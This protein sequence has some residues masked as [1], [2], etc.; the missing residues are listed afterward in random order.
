MTAILLYF[1]SGFVHA[2]GPWPSDNSWNVITS[3]GAPLADR[4]QD[5]VCQDPTNGGA[6]PSQENDIGSQSKCNAAPRYNPGFRDEQFTPGT[7]QPGATIRNTYSAA[8]YY[9]DPNDDSNGCNGIADDTFYFRV[10]IAGDPLDNNA[11]RGFKN[12]FWWANLDIDG[13]NLTDFY[14]RVDGNG[15]KPAENITLI[16]EEST[17]PLDPLD[18][19][20]TGEPTIKV[21]A[22]PLD[23]AI[24]RAILTDNAV[25][26]GGEY[27]VDWQVPITDFDNSGGSQLLCH[28]N[29]MV[30]TNYSTSD[31]NQPLSPY[32]KDYIQ[33]AGTVSDRID[34]VKSEYKITKT[35]TDVNGVPLY[36]GDEVEYTI[37]A[38]NLASN[39]TNFVFTDAIPAGASYVPN[40]IKVILA[41]TTYNMTDA[42][43]TP[44]AGGCSPS[45]NC[46]ADYNVTT[47]G[48]ITVRNDWIYAAGSANPL[49]D[50]IYI[51]FRVTYPL[52]G[53]YYNQGSGVTVELPNKQLTDDP[54]IDDL[55]DCAAPL[56]Y[57]CG[58]GDTGNDDPTGVT[59]AAPAPFANLSVTKTD[60]ITS[61][62][63]GNTL[64]YTITASNAGPFAVVGGTVTDNFPAALTG[65]T[66][67]CVASGGSSCTGAGIG[68][69]NDSAVNLLVGGTATYTVNATV[70]P[71]ASGLL[72]NT[73]TI[74]T[75]PAN[76]DP[77]LSNNTASDSDTLVPTDFGDAPDPAYPTLLANNGARHSIAT[78]FYL[79]ATVDQ[80]PNGQ[81]NATATG[82]D[83][84]G[85]DDEDGVNF[86]SP[87][88]QGYSA[89]LTVSASMAGKLDAWVDFNADGDWADGSEQVFAS[90]NLSA[91]ANAISFAVPA[92]ATLGTTTARFRFS[93]AGGLSYTGSAADGEV[94]DHQL[95]ILAQPNLNTSTKADNDVDNT[96]DP[97]QL[98]TYTVTVINTGGSTATGVNISDT[99]DTDLENLSVI[100]VNNC[101]GAVNSSTANPPV[102]NITGAS[103]AVGTN[104]IITF[105]ANVKPGALGGA[106]IPNTATISAPAEGGPGAAPI[107]DLLTVASI[108][109]LSTSTK[110]DDDG[111][112]SVTNGQTV[113]Y[114]VTVI[115]TGNATGTGINITDTLDTD[116]DNLVVTGITSCGAPADLSVNSPAALNITGASVAVGTNCV[117]TFTADVKL[118][119]PGGSLI[120]NAATISPA[121]E[122]GLGATASSD[123]LAIGA[124]IDLSSSY[125]T[126]NDADDI[127]APGDT[128]T[129]TINVNNTGNSNATGLTV[130]DLIDGDVGAP[131]NF[132]YSGCGAPASGFIA[133]T[134]TFTGVDVAALAS[135]SISY[136]VT[137]DNPIID[138]APETKTVTNSA[139][140][141]PANGS[142]TMTASALSVNVT[143]D[144]STSTKADDD[145]D[146][147]V[148]AG[149]T[150]TYTVTINN[151]GDG[152]ASG[153]SVTDNA[154]FNFGNLSV[155][156][157][158]ACGGSYVNSSTAE[159]PVLNI[160]GIRS[161]PGTPCV[162]T[163]TM[164]VDAGVL[165]GTI[166]ANTANI[167]AALE[168]GSGAAPL[169][170]NLSI[171]VIPN[172]STSTKVDNDADNLVNN[173][174]IVDYTIT[175]IN[176][177]NGTG[178]GISV[179]DALDSD[180]ES[181]IVASFTGCGTPTNGSSASPPILS[182]SGISVALGTNCTI[183]YS[184][185]VKSDSLAGAT[186]PNSA[187]ISAAAEG[188]AGAIPSSDTLTIP[189]NP[190]LSTS[191]KAD[192]DPD[193][194][195][196]NG[197]TVTYTL[198]VINTGNGTGTGVNITD[199]LDTDMENLAVLSINNCGPAVDA[200]VANPPAIN[201][202]G[203]SVGIVAPCTITYTA[204]VKA[205]APGGATIPNTVTVSA[206]SEGG[207]GASPSSDLLAVGAVIDLSGSTKT[208]GDADN[209][210]NPG[211]FVTYS[212]NVVNSG[213][214]NGTGFTVT[215]MIDT[216]YGVP[217]AFSYTG[218][219]A[220]VSSFAAPTLT[221]T[222]VSVAAA[223]TCTIRYTVN[224]DNPLI[225]D[226]PE[227][228]PVDNSADIIPPN[229]SSTS[230][231]NTLS[232]N[233][234]PDLSTSTL[235]DD[236]ADDQVTP[237]QTVTYTLTINNTGDGTATG[238]DINDIIDTNFGNLIVTNISNCGLSY[239]DTSSNE[240]PILTI[241]NLKA[242]PG[243]ACVVTFTAVTDAGLSNGTLLN[244][245][246]SLSSPNE[247]G[248]STGLS[249][250]QLTV[251]VAAPP[252]PPPPPP[253][254]PGSSPGGSAPSSDAFLKVIEANKQKLHEAPEE[255]PPY[256]QCM[257]YNPNRDLYF[258]DVASAN[259]VY[260]K[261]AEILKNTFIVKNGYYIVSGYGSFVKDT[262]V[263][264]IGL[265]RAM[266]RLEWAKILMT[267]HCLPI[268]YTPE[269]GTETATGQPMPEFRDLSRAYNGDETHDRHADMMYSAAYYGILDGTLEGNAEENRLITVAES[270]K[271]LVRTGEIVRKAVSPTADTLV[272]ANIDRNAWYFEFY[273]KAA[274][275]GIIKGLTSSSLKTAT[276][277]V[278]GEAMYELLH[279]LLVRNLYDI[280]Y[281]LL[282]RD[283]LN[284]D[285]LATGKK[286][287]G[288]PA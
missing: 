67:T 229:G 261:T 22:N 179:T 192:D 98:V 243:T 128:V 92:G 172:L 276:N 218:C 202:T 273:S 5:G 114:T 174:Q 23:S 263:R 49:Y 165:G 254:P 66:W 86:T 12:S 287:K 119:S 260:R 278:R 211:D 124:N 37:T 262:G 182:I 73:V 7:L 266:T 288:K 95:T 283:Y 247:G 252:P 105:T 196:A 161:D 123:T 282:I 274:A 166:L 24:A 48:A 52:I 132:A 76:S 78:G 187:T 272:N 43:D 96:V 125:K 277:L 200:S 162:I 163:F 250:S 11:A 138:A 14:V 99:M 32:Q 83:L 62:I 249:A 279:A 267:S 238:I 248:G 116:M 122:G 228:E 17:G 199:T 150:V 286:A 31:A 264:L 58:D 167:S 106:T 217:G 63:P 144:L 198:S 194:N 50:K 208:D 214:A 226:D 133:P 240:P 75:P 54:A 45:T 84:A 42:A 120:P 241:A 245:N 258:S 121:A 35:A 85:S 40:S 93:T 107:S 151:T 41:G 177:G 46:R 57:N 184:A 47:P 80:E 143:P 100:S 71:N 216:N 231:A 271:M 222:N 88:I 109:N 209:L 20:P 126:E 246:L 280:K 224:V 137:V 30:L 3:N 129:Y 15:N 90:Q 185:S 79:G 155:V 152:S 101:G 244:H 60:G 220:P 4:E 275:E 281:Q 242:N 65:V 134:L 180:L 253:A 210:V 111:D 234:T 219:G 181:L 215:D 168:G 102:L 51:K 235:T 118:A 131:F 82:D 19:D 257:G 221:F 28:G 81:P 153:V 139:T 141:S 205:G 61:I 188:G 158:T 29:S 237:G 97:G 1:V 156:S 204:D 39:L 112:N 108:P 176:T 233:V 269:I 104:C 169:S 115:N 236:D 268:M 284:G 146:N 94:E 213:N 27:F 142:G 6:T 69:I 25:G 74:S 227:N 91:G 44:D 136:D 34:L 103:V 193:N 36:T 64:T 160:T 59:V 178:T 2:A 190:D 33:A 157:L 154:D 173:S 148:T 251:N 159:P 225:D 232:I 135:C 212:I 197:Q 26:D 9:G 285:L 70:D 189:I 130:T 56:T 16:H 230:A 77:D 171:P 10:R 191:T 72:T 18:S 13:D 68:N 265:D 203:A 223:S 21:Y 55:A 87:V 89:N 206:A 127:V 195:V 186:I 207:P 147:I 164:Q 183:H 140:I 170:D 201:I 38:E 149:Q 256:E 117:I 255:I 270:I 239:S 259:Q 110:A 175:I 113:T 8:N 145:A 53:T